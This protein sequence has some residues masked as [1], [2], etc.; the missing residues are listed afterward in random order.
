MIFMHTNTIGETTNL[1]N[2]GPITSQLIRRLTWGESSNYAHLCCEEIMPHPTFIPNWIL[3]DHLKVVSIAL[4][5]LVG[6]LLSVKNEHKCSSSARIKVSSLSAFN[7]SFYCS[8]LC[9]TWSSEEHYGAPSPSCLLQ[10]ASEAL[11][12]DLGRP[13]K[14]HIMWWNKLI[15]SFRLVHMLFTNEATFLT[16]SCY[17]FN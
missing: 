12:R 17:F 7:L 9:L 15:Q 13:L 11:A 5:R 3:F 16:I 8:L 10:V 2:I 14:L 4:Q 1:G 6:N